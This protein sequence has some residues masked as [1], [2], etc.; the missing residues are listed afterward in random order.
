MVGS[1]L[2]VDRPACEEEQSHPSVVVLVFGCG[3]RPG[4]LNFQAGF[5]KTLAHRRRLGCFALLNM[6]SRKLPVTGQW[7]A[8]RPLADQKLISPLDDGD[9]DRPDLGGF[10]RGLTLPCGTRR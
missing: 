2:G 9:S 1:A 5:L 10:A 7:F 3:I 6:T 8:G 4:N